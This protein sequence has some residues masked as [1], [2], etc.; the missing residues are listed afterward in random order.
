MFWSLS[1]L[2]NATLFLQWGPW[3]DSSKVT[4]S[5]RILKKDDQFSIIAKHPSWM[6]PCHPSGEDKVRAMEWGPVLTPSVY[7][8]KLEW[9][10]V[11]LVLG[12]QWLH[13]GIT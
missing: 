9:E 8:W 12:Q 11:F 10:P 2:D 5:Q 6:R 7:D 1:E 13:L 3:S 4:L